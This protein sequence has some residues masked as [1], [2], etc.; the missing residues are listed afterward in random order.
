MDLPLPLRRAV[1][2]ILAR[3]PRTDIAQ[4][5]AALS[6]R[7]RGEL[8]G[9]YVPN[10]IAALAYLAARLPA[11]YA[12]TRAS[13][14]AV[15]TLRPD[16]APVTLLD[17]GAGPATALW[18]AADCW[19]DLS[20]ALLIEANPIFRFYGERLLAETQRPNI[21]W[22]TADAATA[23]IDNTA[24]DLVTIAYVLG[25]LAANARLPLVREVWRLTAD[26]LVLVEPGTPAGWQRVME[27]RDAL[28]ANGAHLI[29][30]CPHALACP[31]QP[32]DW[33]HFAQRVARSRVHRA[34]K[35]AELGWED[36]KFIYLAASRKP[37]GSS[38]SRVI[39]RPGKGSGRVT[40]KLC[41][42]DGSAAE[43]LFSRRDGDLYKQAS[44]LVWGGA[45]AGDP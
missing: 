44:R 21:V 41:R 20:D 11:T 42:P 39:A 17:V 25:E 7:Y 29:A 3:A 38:G 12:A 34:A 45:L 10:D 31:L 1:D 24:S 19:P 27:A 36:E 14:D 23:T 16:F 40:L 15:R 22:R 37:C 5:A 32:P 6:Q 13:L 18:A 26:I 8:P 9:P 33:C 43:Q 28:I 2:A 30:P 4:A 35:D